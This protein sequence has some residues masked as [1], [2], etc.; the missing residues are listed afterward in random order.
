MTRIKLTIEFDGAD[1]CGWQLQSGVRTV[2]EELELALAQ[3]LGQPVRVHSSG[4]TDSG[5]HARGMVAHFDSERELPLKAYRE[6][7]NRLLPRDVAILSAE[8]VSAAFHARFSASG[9]W[10]RYSI[11]NDPV[12]SP[13][14]DRRVWHLKSA[15][16]LERM[17]Q[18]AELLVGTHDFAAFRAASCVAKTT[19]R[20]IYSLSLNP[21]GKLV[22]IDVRGSGFLQHMV[23]IIAGTLVEVGQGKR[24]IASVAG[25][26]ESGDRDAAGVTAP[27]SGLCLMEVL[28]PQPCC[29]LA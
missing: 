25:L 24:S 28:Y 4:R 17:Q 19:L 9:K 8:P 6:G 15:L 2:Q 22:H 3:L 14:Q 1:F 20:E 11:W 7:L 29:G 23:R 21:D 18:A 10:Y 27:G 12:R 13:L 5:V 16:D 26:L